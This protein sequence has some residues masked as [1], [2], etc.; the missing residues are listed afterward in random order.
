MTMRFVGLME[1][2]VQQ[3]YSQAANNTYTCSFAILL[4]LHNVAQQTSGN[5]A[6]PQA[7]GAQDH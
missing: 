5:T 4:T 6:A 1:D 7:C 3:Y 2:E